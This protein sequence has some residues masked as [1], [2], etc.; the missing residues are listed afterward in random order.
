MMGLM[1]LAGTPL[2]SNGPLKPTMHRTIVRGGLYI[3]LRACVLEH[4]HS[5]RAAP[6][7]ATWA[8]NSVARVAIPLRH[9]ELELTPTLRT[10]FTETKTTMAFSKAIRRVSLK[11]LA[12]VVIQLGLVLSVTLMGL[13]MC[14]SSAKHSFSL[15]SWK[16]TTYDV[17]M[18]ERYSIWNL[19]WHRVSY[20]LDDHPQPMNS[21]TRFDNAINL[22]QQIQHAADT[23]LPKDIE[24][25]SKRALQAQNEIIPSLPTLFGTLRTDLLAS[26]AL[27]P[28]PKIPL[29]TRCTNVYPLPHQLERYVPLVKYHPRIYLALD[30]KDHADGLSNVLAQLI[31]LSRLLTPEGLE[32]EESRK[33]SHA[34]SS[35]FNPPS[36]SIFNSHNLDVSNLFI[37]LYESDSKDGTARIATTWS[38]AL[39][40]LGIP[41]RVVVN[42]VARSSIPNRIEFLANVRNRALDPLV[43]M[44]RDG[45]V[46]DRV[47]FLND[48]QFCAEDILELIFQSM[49]QDS[50]IT[51]GLDYDLVHSPSEPG[52]Y[53]VWVARDID[54]QE[55]N[56]HPWDFFTP[57][58]ESSARLAQGLPFQA[59]CCFNGVAVYAA[60]P[61]ATRQVQF[62][63]SVQGSECA[64]SECSLICND[65]AKEGYGRVLVV[66][67]VRFAYDTHTYDI[68][69]NV[70]TTR[71]NAASQNASWS[72]FVDF[73]HERIQTWTD[74]P[75]AVLCKGL[76]GNGHHPD[77]AA[78][79]QNVEYG[80]SVYEEKKWMSWWASLF[81]RP[82]QR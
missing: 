30:V 7:F 64:A 45:S 77:K 15:P 50:S 52:F 72:E 69:W 59:Q 75:P 62:R 70:T 81:E 34:F 17:T 11:R 79:W 46:Y 63:R 1:R 82:I 47:V 56:K 13:F 20:G 54:G 39:S 38:T 36:S 53:D 28:L 76:E 25:Q 31:R 71:W 33:S 68:L 74:G 2:L 6:A 8:P 44:W 29:P 49:L 5:E 10:I 4:S 43:D 21:E 66:P 3:G 42:G 57:T 61:L 32:S 48:V 9:Q 27:L 80:A 65:L 73:E 14:S 22:L 26:L 37:S 24:E 16:D 60:K 67:R 58:A 12:L 23:N 19:V 55:F 35:P 78:I 40:I 41:C 51:C 18:S